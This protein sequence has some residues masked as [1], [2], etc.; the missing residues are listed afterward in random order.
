MLCEPAAALLVCRDPMLAPYAM[1]GLR[2]VWLGA[3]LSASLLS[4]SPACRDPVLN[5]KRC[6]LLS[7]PVD[8]VRCLLVCLVLD[9][10][11]SALLL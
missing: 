10:P 11:A 6:A 5:G 7:G 8:R 4:I 3:A 2:I 9:F 1:L